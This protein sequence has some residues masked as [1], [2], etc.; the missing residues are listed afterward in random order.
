[1][2]SEQAMVCVL[3]CVYTMPAPADA[4]KAYNKATAALH[5]GTASLPPTGSHHDTTCIGY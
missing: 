2:F 3:R 5:N 4:S 1:M